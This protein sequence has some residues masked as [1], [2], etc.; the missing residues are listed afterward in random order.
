[1]A[2]TKVSIP[3]EIANVDKLKDLSEKLRKQVLEVDET[4]REIALLKL[5]LK[6]NQ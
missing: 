1:M 6:I 3:V 4:I 5:E 2:E